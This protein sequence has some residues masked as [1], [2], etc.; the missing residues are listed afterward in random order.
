MTDKPTIYQRLAAAQAAM[1]ALKKGAIN[2]FTK[3]KYVDLKSLINTVKP[4]LNKHGLFLR[5]EV[6]GGDDGTVT[7]KTTLFTPEGESLSTEPLKIPFA[8]QN[9]AQAMGAAITYARRYSLM[10][11]LG[12]VGDDDTDG[13]GAY[14]VTEK[15]DDP[16]LS[17]AKQA[18]KEGGT[19]GYLE[20]FRTLSQLNRQKLL[21]SGLHEKF[22]TENKE[23]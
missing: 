3:S 6:S 22:K 5:Q 1:P 15:S 14:E 19:Q 16:V 13:N 12:L 21:K 4:V 17:K 8:G 11:L 20:Y 9:L 23:L 18:Y 2:P 7:I 10:A